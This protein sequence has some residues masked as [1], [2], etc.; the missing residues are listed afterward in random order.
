MIKSFFEKSYIHVFLISVLGILVY[1]NTFT[2]PFQWDE[3]VF[4]RDNPIVKDFGHFLEPSKAESFKYYDE[5]KSRYVGYLTFALNYRLHRFDVVGYH[6]FNNFIHVLNAVLVY[7]LV[8]L[9]G[10]SP[11]LERSQLERQMH[12]VALFTAL[13]FV[14]HPVQTEAVTYIYQRFTSLAAFFC[15]LSLVSYVRSR[16]SLGGKRRLSFY[17][18]SLASAALAMKTKENAF[19]LPLAIVLIEFLFLTGTTKRR[20]LYLLPV[21]MTLLIIPFSEIDLEKPMG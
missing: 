14:S 7:W 21:I 17:A 1:S 11:V 9:I 18:L 6:I 20:A 8:V 15:L 5:M 4:L 19:T 3:N 2:V 16:V 10:K 12:S 13:L